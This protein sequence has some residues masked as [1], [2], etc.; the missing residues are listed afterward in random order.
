MVAKKKSDFVYVTFRKHE[1]VL[2][3]HAISYT[4][5]TKT[6]L[7]TFFEGKRKKKEP[8]EENQASAPQ[9]SSFKQVELA[10]QKAIS[11]Y[12]DVVLSTVKFSPI[13]SSII[14]ARELGQYAEDR[15]TRLSGVDTEG[16]EVYELPRH[17]ITE[18]I[19]KNDEAEAAIAGTRQLP[20]IATI[21]LISAYDAFLSDLLK[22]IFQKKPEV[23]FTS[24]R[25]IKFSELVAFE[26]ISAARD[27]IISEEIEGV[28]R[29]SHHEQFYWMEKRLAIKLRE[30]LEVWPQFIE[31]C[32]RRNLLTH[33]GGIV[34]DQYIKNCK[35]HGVKLQCKVGDRLVVDNTY[36]ESAIEIVAEI[37]IKLVH[38]M[39]RKFE[40]S[41]RHKADRSLN[42]CGM[43]LIQKEKYATAQRILRFGVD[44]KK[45]DS[46]LLRRMMIVNLAN[47]VKLAGS[48][49]QAKQILDSNDW[50]ATS[51]QFRLCVAA[52]KDDF[53]EVCNIL[54]M[55]PSSTD[56]TASDFRDWPVFRTCHDVDSVIK[57]FVDVYKEPLINVRRVEVDAP[58]PSDPAPTEA[59]DEV[60]SAS[61]KTIH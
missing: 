55:G 7:E 36:F 32:E 52:V 37:G 47:A 16:I 17:C 41:E 4:K 58:S 30:N 6:D 26:S 33:T 61:E 3:G 21:G 44:Q 14:I 40:E 19:R 2:T 23:I 8:E 57:V 15:G 45:H 38:T 35:E 24:E 11:M 27:S 39:W 48:I 20:Q 56:V 49:D 54:K 29:K 9:P 51:P 46:D 42:D 28:L 43:Q 12:R 5:P 10:F 22:V 60:E 13:V 34:S 53:E 31:L 25:E 1:D 59:A 50:S 18:I